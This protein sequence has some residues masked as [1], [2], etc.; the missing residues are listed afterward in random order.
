MIVALPTPIED[1]RR[2]DL[3]PVKSAT[4]TVGRNLKEGA[5]GVFESTVSPGLTEEVCV[6]ILERESGL[7]WKEHFHVGYSPE[8]ISP[9][10]R[11][12]SP[13]GPACRP[14]GQ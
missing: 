4:A 5:V 11:G 9:G 14:K 7:R 1:S 12:L 3:G 6:P 2:P 8:R 13:P 10:D